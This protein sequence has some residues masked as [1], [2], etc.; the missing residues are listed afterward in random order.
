MGGGQCIIDRY[1][2]TASK[3]EAQVPLWVRE[4]TD[5]FG[6]VNECLSTEQCEEYVQHTLG[7]HDRAS[8]LTP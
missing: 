4:T 1:G 3:R 5:E 7:T 8:Q 6:S 2:V